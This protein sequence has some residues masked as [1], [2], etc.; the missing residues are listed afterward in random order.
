[1]LFLSAFIA[2]FYKA[3]YIN[4]DVL[5]HFLQ[6]SLLSMIIEG[7]CEY[8]QVFEKDNYE[9]WGQT[10]RKWPRLE[11]RQLGSGKDLPV[12]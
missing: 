6:Y 4:L 1:M 12:F 7:K 10:L 8:F 2:I 9:P 11:R 5:L 3:Y